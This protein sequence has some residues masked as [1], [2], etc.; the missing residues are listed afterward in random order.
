[1]TG[2]SSLC[3]VDLKKN[4]YFQILLFSNTVQPRQA[5][6]KK[7]RNIAWHFTDIKEGPL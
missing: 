4:T 7:L 5:L 6:K 1:M 2:N 3:T